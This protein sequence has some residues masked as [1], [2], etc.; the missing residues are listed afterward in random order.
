MVK[1]QSL[2]LTWSLC[3][4]G[5]DKQTDKQTDGQNYHS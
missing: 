3:V 5:R 4:P 1:T 2:Y